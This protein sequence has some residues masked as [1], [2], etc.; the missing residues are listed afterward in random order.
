MSKTLMILAHPNIEQSIGNRIIR[1]LC[2]NQ[3]DVSVR[4]LDALYP[5]FKINVELEQAALLSAETI[6][7]QF[8]LYWYSTPAILKEWI[9]QVLQY[10]FAFGHDSKLDNK[11]LIVSFTVG[12]PD[13][14]YPQEVIDKI[15]FPFQGTA[16]Y[17]KMKYK[18]EVVCFNINNYAE[19]AG[20]KAAQF[21]KEH[22]QKLIA[23]INQ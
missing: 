6:I 20:E 23:L 12:S 8:P 7:L 11:E 1:E 21:A 9:D 13:R 10:G 17:C 18:G 4:H 15:T 22:A 2:A 16:S 19:G 14:D 3:S 5:D